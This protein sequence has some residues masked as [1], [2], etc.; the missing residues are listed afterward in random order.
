MDKTLATSVP[1][2]LV[3]YRSI[4][5]RYPTSPVAE[6]A[7]ERLA[8]LRRPQALRTRPPG[9]GDR[10]PAKLQPEPPGRLGGRANCIAER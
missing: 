8:D 2:Q 4:V 3:S 5:E 1:A 10:W 9:R 7:H 6:G